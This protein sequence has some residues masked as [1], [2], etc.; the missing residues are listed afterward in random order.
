MTTVIVSGPVANKPGN[1]GIV[2]NELSYVLGLRR[3]GFDVHFWEQ[4]D[5]GACVT[6][7]GAPSDFEDSIN[8][9]YF[10]QVVAVS[11]I[12][13]S[14]A[15]IYNEGDEVY[16]AQM[17][18]LVAVAQ[19][20]ALL[21]N[22]SGHL[23]NDL[24]RSRV[25]SAVYIDEDPGYT[26]FWHEAGARG[27]GLAGHDYFYTVG[28]NIG[29]PDCG[30]PTNGIAWRPI[31]QPV[32][33]DEWPFGPVSEFSGFTT[34]ASWRGAFGPV[35]FDGKRY[36]LKVHEFRKF[37]SLPALTGLPFEVALDIE[38]ADE[39][40]R[41]SLLA[42]EWKLLHPACVVAD[43]LQ[44]RCFVQASGAEF[45]VTQG[46]YTETNSG[47]FSDRSVRYLASGKPVLLQ[48]TGFSRNLPVDEGLV[49]FRTLDEAVAGARAIAS[50]YRGHCEAAR[51]IAESCFDSDLVLGR[52]IEE[53][54]VAP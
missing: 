30:I 8:L 53:L 33:I 38:P 28:E 44:F 36:G 5:A 50:D 15:L 7:N 47:W 41:V 2:W 17:S 4:I 52:L 6:A 23:Q 39:K 26:Q 29:A 19:D 27:S 25:R 37:S 16:G 43:P 46:I 31:R 12:S 24:L 3:L 18:D 48:D 35:E 40:D 13:E 42:Q 54:G 14:A 51:A 20:A 10:K 22:I 49:P 1:G 45:S 21:L 34:V 32:V 9:E 11:G